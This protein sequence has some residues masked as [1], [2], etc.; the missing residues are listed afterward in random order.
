MPGFQ[1][2]LKTGDTLT[3]DCTYTI[4]GVIQSLENVSVACTIERLD[5]RQNMTVEIVNASAGTF[6]LSLTPA[7]TEAL[8]IGWYNADIQYTDN[9]GQ[10]ISTETFEFRVEKDI[11]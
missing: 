9:A 7:Q 5:T 2:P 6:K 8:P 4:S 1:R 10:V 11:T 3:F